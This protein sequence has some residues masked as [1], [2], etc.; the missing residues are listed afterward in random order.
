MHVSILTFG[1]TVLKLGVFGSPLP[2]ISDEENTVMALRD[3]LPQLETIAT[4]DDFKEAPLVR[5]WESSNGD[6]GAG[7][8]VSAG[9]GVGD[10]LLNPKPVDPISPPS[11][12]ISPPSNPVP[13]PSNPVPPPSDPIPPPVTLPVIPVTPPDIPPVEDSLEPDPTY[14]VSPILGHPL[15]PVIAAKHRLL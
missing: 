7:I 3:A 2:R 13:P 11:N 15:D 14:P 4:P 5:R 10:L 8:G 6:G 9:P 1:L 12:P